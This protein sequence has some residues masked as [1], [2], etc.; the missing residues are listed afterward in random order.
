MQQP[1]SKWSH[2]G[3]IAKEEHEKLKAMNP[4]AY[5]RGKRMSVGMFDESILAEAALLVNGS[6]QQD[7][8]PPEKCFA[9]I[10]RVWGALLGIPDIPPRKVAHMMSGL[11]M[12]R[13]GYQTKRDSLVDIV[14]YVLCASV[15]K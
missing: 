14:G 8:G 4:E 7:Y 2:F 13:D 6:R 11:K 10:G 15:L 9:E 3:D 1:E 12:V 5:A